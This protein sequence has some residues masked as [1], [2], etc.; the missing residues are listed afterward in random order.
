MQKYYIYLNINSCSESESV[1]EQDVIVGVG[2][3]GT[4]LYQL[5]KNGVERVLIYDNDSD[6]FQFS[7]EELKQ[8]CC[9]IL[10]VCF[11]YTIKFLS[12][13]IRYVDDFPCKELVIHSTVR[14]GTTVRLQKMLDVPVIYSPFRGVHVRMLEDLKRYTKYWST[15][16][17]DAVK[18]YPAE[19]KKCKLKTKIW[20]STTQLELA[21]ILM[22]TTYYGWL[23][24]FAQRVKILCDKYDVDEPTIWEFT[25]EIHEF[26]GNRPLMFPG[27][28]IRGHC[29]LQNLEILD[30][31]FMDLVF[32]HDK[33]F[34]RHLR[35]KSQF[36]VFQADS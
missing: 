29:V 13:V 7:N 31:D 10:H 1:I 27:S 23:I 36:R 21:K 32:S 6:K 22:D 33:L 4:A 2:E 19:L 5:L 24:L 9:N 16:D 8:R 20:G 14:P 15:K 25:E 30:D 18:L 12:L 26:L 34:R 17:K 3:V 35:L 28:G 11:P